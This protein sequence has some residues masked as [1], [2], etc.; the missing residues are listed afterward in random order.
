MITTEFTPIRIS[1]D[2]P[3]GLVAQ[4]YNHPLF[5]NFLFTYLFSVK[6]RVNTCRLLLTYDCMNMDANRLN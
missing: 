4:N 5:F 2:K 6:F 3:Q 1:H